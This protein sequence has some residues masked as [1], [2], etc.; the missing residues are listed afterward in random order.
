M[1]IQLLARTQLVTTSVLYCCIGCSSM[2]QGPK[3]EGY[4]L[5]DSMSVET[6]G[7]AH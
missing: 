2:S 5:H 3:E 6:L 1:I 7:P 4:Q